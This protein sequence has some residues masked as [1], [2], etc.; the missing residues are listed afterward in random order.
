MTGEPFIPE[1]ITVHLGRPD[2]GTAGNITV[3]FPDYIKN[4]ASS[5]I[6]PTWPESALRAN[7]YAIIS[8]TLN[9]YYTEWYRSQGYDFDITS[10]IQYDQTFIENRE[11][12]E[13]ISNIVDNIFNDYIQR[14]GNIEPL[15]AAY[16]DGDEVQCD[17]LS[18]WG[19]V[20]L[21]RQGYIP[22]DILRYYYGDDINIIQDAPVRPSIQS[23]PG[24]PLVFGDLS[25]DVAFI[26]RQL[27]R[28]SNNYPAIPKIYPLDG[29]FDD[30]T[31]SAVAKFQEI[32]NIPQSG[33]VDKATWY[34]INY[35][36]NSVK[37]LS[38]LDSEGL[39]LA[40]VSLQLPEELR[41]GD[42]GPLVTYLQYYL[43]VIGAYYRSVTPAEITGEFDNA[44]VS[45]VR[46]FQNVFGLEPTGVLNQR[47]WDDIARAYNGI[48]ESVPVTETGANAVLYPGFI[49]TEGVTN[50][51]VRILQ[52]YLN[53]IH[54]T[55][56]QIPLVSATGYFGPLTRN[57]VTA[58]QNLFGI[59]ATGSVGPV[60][61]NEIS[62]I[63]S[64]LR[65][66]YEKRPGQY[67]GYIIG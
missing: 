17:G 54:G 25:N 43:S 50:D 12:F 9:R 57:A 8:Y 61:W 33:G 28:I 41:A 37:R 30:E 35:I 46:S 23:Y 44:T 63:Y 32:F 29:F 66:G 60:T 4:V 55:Y 10:S 15:F 48:V 11:I 59:Q 14:Q 21:A 7:I 13:P 56:A 38:Q 19:S 20:E 1:T 34:K 49:L 42:A 40:D 31:R 67:P 58:F 64:D 47:T 53:Y 6:Y 22:Y 5:E 65:Y 26:Q 45:S 36:Y 27:N 24:S 51:Y 62:N 2:D 3:S 18:Q 39:S 52:E 16:C